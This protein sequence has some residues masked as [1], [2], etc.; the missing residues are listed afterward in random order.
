MV[1]K[2]TAKQAVGRRAAA[3]VEDGT[4]VGLGTGSTTRFALEE[5]GRRIRQEGLRIIGTATSSAS[6]RLARQLGIPLATLDDIEGIDIAIDGADEVDPDF[7]LIKGR[8]AAHSRE[9]VIASIAERFVVLVDESKLVD[10]LGS[11]APVPVEVLPM[12]AR[13]VAGAL[14]DFGA[15]VELR[16][17]HSKDGPVVTD[18]GFWVLDATFGGIADPEGL[19]RAIKQIPGVLDHGLFVG[20]ATDVFVGLEDGSVRQ[21]ERALY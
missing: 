16:M 21:L 1:D 15:D 4:C 13:P 6:E 2:E 3:L 10:R 5:L 8:G 19:A 9:K 17:G 12:A 11:K 7:N 20:M 14:E 18:Q